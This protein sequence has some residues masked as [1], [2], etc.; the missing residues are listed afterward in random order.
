MPAD[1][2]SDNRK[3]RHEYH[4]EQLFEAGI[5]LEGWEVKSLRAGKAQLAESYV[6]LRQGE[7]FLLNAHI[8]P[9]HTTALHWAGKPNRTRKLLLHRHELDRLVGQV[10]RK[11][12]TLVPVNLHWHHNRAKLSLALAKG[13]NLH[14]KRLATK[15]RDWQREQKN[16][17]KLKSRN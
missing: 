1:I 14:D 4:F 5:V 3:S 7:A 16:L 11:G 13:K 15:E 2:I 6:V 12:Y 9:Q 8:S 17:A 10:K